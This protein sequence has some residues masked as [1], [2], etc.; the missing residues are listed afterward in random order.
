[1]QLKLD[2]KT[3]IIGIALGVILAIALGADIGSADAARFGIA[4]DPKGSA[5]VQTSA[6][7]FYIVNAHNGMA[8]PV[9]Q[10]R[11]PNADPDD[12]RDSRGRPFSSASTT[13]PARRTSRTID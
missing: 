8:T 1:M 4:I 3:L 2:V 9:L 6:G 13:Q 7:D 10:V 5:V 11:S 12:A